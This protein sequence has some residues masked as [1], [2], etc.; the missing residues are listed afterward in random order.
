MPSFELK[1]LSNTPY[2]DE[3]TDSREDMKEQ[4]TDWFH[5]NFE[6]PIDNMP[7]N[8]ETGSFDWIW[9]GPF[10]A[11]EEI[12][13]AF[14]GVDS[15]ILDEV[16]EEIEFGGRE[17][18]PHSDRVIVVDTQQAKYDD[19]QRRIAEL[20]TILETVRPTPSAIGGNNPPETIGL[21]PYGEEDDEELREALAVLKRPIGVLSADVQGFV[22]ATSKVRTKS[23]MVKD[24]LARHGET[25]AESF[26]DQLGKRVADSITIASWLKL[27][28]ALYAVYEAAQSFVASIGQLPLP[29]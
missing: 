18:A 21:P 26:S 25:F 7:R 22:S 28:V 14:I 11:R 17:W 27:S 24:F 9:G 12:E 15:E 4:I 1:P 23:E 13:D 8:P 3:D 5:E 19:L 2:V 6:D 10:D 29:F 20:E 16:I